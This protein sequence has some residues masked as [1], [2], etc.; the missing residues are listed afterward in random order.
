MGV[1]Y[2]GVGGI[3][4]EFTYEQL[5]MV[6]NKGLLED[7]DAPDKIDTDYF[8]EYLE[9]LDLGYEC[10]GDAYGGEKCYYV[11]VPG[12]NLTEINQNSKA[13]IERLGSLGINITEDDLMVISD[14]YIY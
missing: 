1:D 11:L 4:I 9:E 6:V 14:L 2:R 12:K 10:G 8:G 7:I 13:F 3:G 5:K